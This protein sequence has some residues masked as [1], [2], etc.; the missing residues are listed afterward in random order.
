M[1][2]LANVLL[3]I[4]AG[5]A[6]AARPN[7]VISKTEA[8]STAHRSTRSRPFDPVWHERRSGLDRI[9]PIY[10]PGQLVPVGEPLMMHV[11]MLS[12]ILTQG[13]FSQPRVGKSIMVMNREALPAGA[14]SS[15]L[16]LPQSFQWAKGPKPTLY[17]WALSHGEKLVVN[18]AGKFRVAVPAGRGQY[19]LREPTPEER[20]DINVDR[21]TP[22]VERAVKL[23][24]RAWRSPEGL[25]PKDGKVP[26]LYANYRTFRGFT[27]PSF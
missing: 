8:Q 27:L 14:T 25:S 6:H 1:A 4:L 12:D 3:F 7:Q 13:Y 11:E 21:A 18:Q 19:S 26:L 22:L 5:S 2:R 24:S 17:L 10:T 9:H 15:G 23:L 16:R 20:H